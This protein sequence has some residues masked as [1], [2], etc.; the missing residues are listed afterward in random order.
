VI[1]G[2]VNALRHPIVR[3]VVRGLEGREQV[4]E[5]LVDTGFDGTLLLP[6][7][8]VSTL[9]LPFHGSRTVLL[10]DG[11]FHEVANHKGR[12]L[13]E[14]IERP[15]CIVAAGSQPLLGMTLFVG[16]RLCVDMVDGGVVTADVL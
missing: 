16:Y 13:W 3:I 1:R 7:D 8:L 6:P 15:I 9:A 2:T 14:G 4:V 10:A 5:G 11:N 12:I